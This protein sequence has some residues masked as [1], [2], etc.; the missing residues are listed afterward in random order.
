MGIEYSLGFAA[1]SSEAIA[2]VVRRLPAVR[3]LHAPDHRFVLG[4][5]E[6]VSDWPEATVIMETGGLYFC[7]HCGGGGQ[8]AINVV[9]AAMTS[10][11]GPVAVEEL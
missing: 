7:D 4:L 1:P 3:E 6:S 9:V 5:D 2:D 10:A 8:A 11:F